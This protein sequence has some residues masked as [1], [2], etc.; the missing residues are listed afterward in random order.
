MSLHAPGLHTARPMHLTLPACLLPPPPP[1]S[2]VNSGMVK[3]YQAE[4]LAKFPIMQHFLFGS[5]IQWAPE[6]LAAPHG[7]SAA[8]A[9]TAAAPAVAAG[10]Q[11]AGDEQA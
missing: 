4:V 10:E 3:M 11:A 7:T 8:A 6:R 1:L 5:L 2:Q 9:P